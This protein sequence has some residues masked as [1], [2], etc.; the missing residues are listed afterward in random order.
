MDSKF[1]E[2][3]PTYI[4]WGCEDECGSCKD[5]E[6]DLGHEININYLK[7]IGRPCLCAKCADR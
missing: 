1:R 2:F 4:E 3:C 6:S 7:S 5:T